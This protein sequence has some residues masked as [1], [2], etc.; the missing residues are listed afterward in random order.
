[1]SSNTWGSSSPVR[2]EHSMYMS[3]RISWAAW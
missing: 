2:A 1:M 3:A